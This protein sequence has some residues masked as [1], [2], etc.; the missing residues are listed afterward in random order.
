PRAGL[1]RFLLSSKGKKAIQSGSEKNIHSCLLENRPH[2]SQLLRAIQSYEKVCRFLYNAF[3]EILQWMEKNQGKANV[4]QLSKLSHVV[5]ACKGLRVSFRET[6]LLLADFSYESALFAENFL[7]LRES[8]KP[9]DW[10]KLLFD[11][12]I[13]VQKNKPPI[14]KAPWVLEHSSGNY[15]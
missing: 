5:H 6:D 2:C 9:Q 7:Y 13:N 10:V 15:L 12:H 1:I 3:Y 14:G 4:N 8:N 11:H